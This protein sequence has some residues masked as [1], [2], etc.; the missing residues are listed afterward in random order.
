MTPL[1]LAEWLR[2]DTEIALIGALAAAACALPGCFLVLRRMSMMGDAISHAV[3]PGL[4][5]AFLISGTRDSM[6][7][8]AGA[9]VVGV[10]TAAFTQWIHTAG[11]VDEG[12]SMG[13]VF[14]VLFAVGLVLLRQA[15]DKVD[16]DPDCVLYGAIEYAPLHRATLF[17]LDLPRA[18]LTTGGV[19]VANALVIGLLFKELRIAAFDPAL[20]TTMGISARL[21]HYLLMTLVAVTT[22]VVFESVGSV[23]VIAMLIVP[24]AAAHLLTDRLRVMLPLSAF[25]AVASAVAGHWSAINVPPLLGYADASTSTAGM[26]AAASGSI[27]LAALLL[28]PRYGLLSR[29]ARRARL[30]LRI[31][32]EDLLGLLYR[33][34]EH[35]ASGAAVHARAVM[36]R[37]EALA[38]VRR[39]AD[40]GR[41]AARLAEAELRRRGF[42]ARQAG[43]LCLTP[44]GRSQARGLVR[45]H[46]LWE[47]YFH[48]WLGLPADHIHAPACRLEHVTGA[49]LGEQLAANVAFAQTDPHGDEIPAKPRSAE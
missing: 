27:F 12:A 23:L 7:M 40:V 36:P 29:W 8:V 11:R 25:L 45:S 42:V 24:A 34:E 14:T 4:A 18:A 28:G 21:I 17:G 9:I 2:L 32:R 22:V 10:L 37:M 41:F 3:L 15:A 6:A 20:A 30:T 43:A 5:V 39:A 31:V 33:V 46:R 35:N 47:T 49:A 26:I 44:A 16:L 13:V 48:Q 38:I 1:F 19:L